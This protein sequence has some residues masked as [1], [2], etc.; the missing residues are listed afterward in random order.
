[1]ASSISRLDILLLRFRFFGW[2]VGSVAV[3]AVAV[4]LPGLVV[5]FAAALVLLGLIVVLVAF[6]WPEVIVFFIKFFL[7]RVQVL[8]ASKV[9]PKLWL[10]ANASRARGLQLNRFF[11]LF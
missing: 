5:L 9:L 11:V 7:T 8:V 4:L 2:E 10:L 1:M 3:H 6:S